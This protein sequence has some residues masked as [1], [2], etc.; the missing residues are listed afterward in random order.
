MASLKRFWDSPTGTCSYL[1][2]SCVSGQAVFID[3]VREQVPLYLGVLEEMGLAL[4]GILETHVHADHDTA[5][6][7]LRQRTGATVVCARGSGVRGADRLLGDGEYAVFGDITLQALA[8]PG[9]TAACL[10]YRWGDRLFT[11]DT[12]LIGGCGRTD[13][14]G[15]NPGRLFDSLARRLLTLPDELLVYPGHG[16]Q[17]RWVSCV[18]EERR[19]NP[20]LLGVSR[21]EF[22][23]LCSR[24]ETP[25]IPNL[26]GTLAANR[27]CGEIPAPEDRAANEYQ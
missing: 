4:T 24:R 10:S 23:S 15:S 16:S 25:P 13:E 18:G 6:A 11:G 21:D 19:S 26:D 9:H 12:L 3:P 2:G 22:I 7:L 5:A 27:R 8:T 20:L 1:I 17:Q 14:P